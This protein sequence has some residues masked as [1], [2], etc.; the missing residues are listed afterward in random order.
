MAKDYYNILGVGKRASQE[1]IK[2]AF[3]KLAHQHHPDKSGGDEAKFKEA[4]EAYQVLGDPEKRAKYDQFGS[5]AFFAGGR[6][7]YGGEQGGFGGGQGFGGFGHGFSAGGGSGFAGEGVDLGD[8]FGDLGDMFGFSSGGG[9]G[10]RG[11]PRGADIQV[12]LE[13]NFHDAVF[14]IERE[15]SLTKAVKCE[16]CAGLGAEP[17]TKMKDCDTCGGSGSIVHQQRT[18]LGT[19]QTRRLCSACQGEGQTPETVCKNCRGI[20]LE[21]KR[22][23]MSVRIPEGVSEGDMIRVRGEG[24]AVKSGTSGDLYLRVHV[25]PDSRFERD[26]H[27]IRSRAEIGFTQAA[28]GTEVDVP[29]VDGGEVTLKIPPGIQSGTELRLKGKGVPAKGSR[30]DHLVIVQIVTPKKLSRQQRK[31]LEE[32]DA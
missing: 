25:R 11:T 20:G 8:I 19:M 5:A 24:E 22:K 12:D 3:R 7:A 21:H 1:E 9:R 29:V 10:R 31:L 18:M 13:L 15:V 26:G 27:T 16:R 2:K 28:L 32:L 23:T 6:S 4:N 14:G 30:G 17:G